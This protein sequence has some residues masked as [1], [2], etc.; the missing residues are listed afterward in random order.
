MLSWLFGACFVFVSHTNLIA[1]KLPSPGYDMAG[2]S[3]WL[4]SHDMMSC[5]LANEYCVIKY[6]LF[7]IARSICLSIFRHSLNILHKSPHKTGMSGQILSCSVIAKSWL[8]TYLL[9]KLSCCH[10]NWAC[11]TA[12]RFVLETQAPNRGGPTSDNFAR[13]FR[14]QEKKEIFSKLW[15]PRLTLNY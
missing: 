12:V 10:G 15:R 9:S 5:L 14:M 2:D 8:C 13:H 1:A 11:S 4:Y 3:T 7:T 6:G